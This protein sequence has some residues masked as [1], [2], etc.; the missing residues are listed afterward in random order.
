MRADPK[1]GGVL[2]ASTVLKRDT[3]KG[4]DATRKSG[5][6]IVQKLGLVWELIYLLYLLLLV[7]MINRWVCV[8]ADS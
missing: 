1:K 2:G 4:A 3:K 5:S 8:L 6:E 7:N